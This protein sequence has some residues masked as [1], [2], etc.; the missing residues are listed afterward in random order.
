MDTNAPQALDTNALLLESAALM[1]EWSRNH[2]AFKTTGGMEEWGK[3]RNAGQ[4]A[5]PVG[6]CDWYHGTWQV[7][8]LLDMVAVPPWYEFYNRALSTVLRAKPRAN[9]LIS[10]CADL[11][12]LATLHDAIETAGARPTITIYD[13]CETPL[14]SARWYAERNELDVECVCDNLL[15]SPT[16]PLG[17]FDLVVTDEFLTVIKDPDKPTIVERWRQF[18]RPGG[19]LVTT[20]MIGSPTTPELRKRYAAKARRLLDENYHRLGSLGASLEDLKARTDRF[21]ELHTRHMFIDEAA[22]RSLFSDFQLTL[23]RTSTPGECVNPTS[24]FQIVATVS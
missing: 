8:R 19:T 21:A 16:I 22:V 2:C 14:R 18:L 23:S 24:S 10:A 9:V 5:E 4:A 13:I 1:W 11:G 15:T 3:N 12:M 17:C 6:S 20:A 7:L